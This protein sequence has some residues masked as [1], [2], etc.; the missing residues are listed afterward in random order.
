MHLKVARCR[1]RRKLERPEPLDE[2]SGDPCSCKAGGH[3]EVQAWRRQVG[4]GRR[5]VEVHK[6][7]R[8]RKHRSTADELA[9]QAILDR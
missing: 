2:D 7:A 8:E 3:H 5:E 1:W 9:L 4:L 6:V